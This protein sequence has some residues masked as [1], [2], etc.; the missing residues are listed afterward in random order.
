MPLHCCASQYCRISN[1]ARETSMN[2]P[3]RLA[4]PPA[5]NRLREPSASTDE[6]EQALGWECA[7]P[8]LQIER[9]LQDLEAGSAL[10][11]SN[12]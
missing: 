10:P 4:V 2:D 11:S 9:W 7:H 6:D 8:A 1:R 5:R 3:Q 12:S